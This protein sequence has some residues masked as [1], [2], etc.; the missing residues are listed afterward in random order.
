MTTI[1]AFFLEIRALFPIFEKR[2]NLRPFFSLFVAH[3]DLIFVF[4]GKRFL[5]HFRVTLH[6]YTP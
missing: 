4:H 3:F 1:K 2:L 6:L 5:T